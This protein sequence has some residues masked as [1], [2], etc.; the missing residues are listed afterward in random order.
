MNFAF[1]GTP[2]FSAIVL[3]ELL[4]SGYHPSLVVTAPDKPVGRKQILTQS[5]VKEFA[6][7]NRL[8]VATPKNSNELFLAMKQWNNETMISSLYISLFFC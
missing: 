1:F 6:V 4:N 3:E 5:P 7:K 8:N 2:H